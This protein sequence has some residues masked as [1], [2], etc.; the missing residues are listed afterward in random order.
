MIV[1]CRQHH[2]VRHVGHPGRVAEIGDPGPAQ[3]PVILAPQ[4]RLQNTSVE[5]EAIVADKADDPGRLVDRV[6]R[7]VKRSRSVTSFGVLAQGR[8]DRLHTPVG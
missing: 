6:T 4:C 5:L 8:C 7:E 3:R 2:L 1:K